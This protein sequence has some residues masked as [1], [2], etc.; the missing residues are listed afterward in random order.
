MAIETIRQ[1]QSE[2]EREIEELANEER[3][4]LDTFDDPNSEDA[5]VV[6]ELRYDM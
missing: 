1:Q 2:I 4:Y 6:I 3:Q 5:N